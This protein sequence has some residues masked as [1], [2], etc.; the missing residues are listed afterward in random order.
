M[1]TLIAW[2]KSKLLPAALGLNLA[3][4]ELIRSLEDLI[5]ILENGFPEVDRTTSSPKN[6]P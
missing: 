5:P 2:S 3:D 6:E 1:R 4:W